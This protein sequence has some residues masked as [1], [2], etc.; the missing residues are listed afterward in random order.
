MRA[1]CSCVS[2]G[3]VRSDRLGS[4]AGTVEVRSAI[5]MRSR[6]PQNNHAPRAMNAATNTMITTSG[7][8]NGIDPA[9]GLDGESRQ[10]RAAAARGSHANERHHR[11]QLQQ[12]H[13]SKECKLDP[14]EPVTPVET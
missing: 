14:E 10:R 13:G 6:L 7:D 9:V 8:F 5:S 2:V 12:E 11:R 3:N 1:S 4:V